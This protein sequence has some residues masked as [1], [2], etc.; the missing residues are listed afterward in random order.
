MTNILITWNKYMKI[1]AKVFWYCFHEWNTRL[2]PPIYL[3]L[4][5]YILMQPISHT[6]QEI[7]LSGT[8][9]ADIHPNTFWGLGTLV[10]LRIFGTTLRKMP[11]LSNWSCFLEHL[12][13]SNNLISNSGVIL[14]D[15]FCKLKYLFLASN[16]LTVVPDFRHVALSLTH[17]DL[18]DNCLESLCK[19]YHVQ[20]IQLK[21][22]LLRK[23]CLKLISLVNLLLPM[24]LHLD[25]N[26]NS[27]TTMEPID[28]LNLDIEL[29][30]KSDYRLSL[31]LDENPW[32][33]NDSFAWLY[34]DLQPP[35]YVCTYLL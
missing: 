12:D 1:S 25:I 6:P 20:F 35:D 18:S 10:T 13:F 30:N 9:L 32:H 19:L 8:P 7:Q 28:N 31:T 16:R 27:V 33:C 26:G 3:R 15:G 17:L 11:P 24:L 4:L 34:E 5:R 14:T 22:L 21:E 2:L 29:R 23:T